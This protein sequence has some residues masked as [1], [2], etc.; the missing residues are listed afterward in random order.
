MSRFRGGPRGKTERDEASPPKCENVVIGTQAANRVVARA[1]EGDLDL[2]SLAVVLWRRR[3]VVGLVALGTTFV[4]LG[5]TL[6][7]PKTYTATA[8]ILPI[9]AND[10]VVGFADSLAAQLG[11]TFGG[12]SRG[13]GTSSDLVEILGSRAMAE[14]VIQKLHLE[15]TLK[16]WKTHTQ[17]VSS[18]QHMAKIDPPSTKSKAIG[19]SILGGKPELVAAVANAYVDGLKD[20]LDEIGYNQAARNRKFIEGQL[21]KARTELQSAEEKLS[22]FQAANRLASLPDTISASIQ[23]ISSLE[24][25]RISAEVQERTTEE[26]LRAMRS[27]VDS[28]QADPNSLVGLEVQKKGLERQK[29]ALNQAKDTFLHQL[30]TLPPEA[31]ALARLQ[32]DVQVENAV[33]LALRQQYESAIISENKDSDAFYPLDRADVPERPAA[34][35]LMFN[36]AVGLG[37]GLLLG[38]LSAFMK[39]YLEVRLPAKRIE[40]VSP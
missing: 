12:L 10:P 25:Q 24:A 32:R 11:A 35:R 38:I 19:I 28:L 5:W 22:R 34:P 18:V 7:T 39:A 26:A 1:P 40:G 27:K 9:G 8:T 29:T 37:A 21:G 4:V 3:A 33:Y 23:S 36:T 16:G 17:L 30:N 6:V 31:M 2:I 20:M 15:R 14:R 13:G